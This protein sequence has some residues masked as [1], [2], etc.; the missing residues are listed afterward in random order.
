VKRFQTQI[1]AA[2]PKV[3]LDLNR[4]DTRRALPRNDQSADFEWNRI[5]HSLLVGLSKITVPRARAI[6]VKWI[7]GSIHNFVGQYIHFI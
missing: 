5:D 6:L 3:F 4:V 7:E 2:L 1:V